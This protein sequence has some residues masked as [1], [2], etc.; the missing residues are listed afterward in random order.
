MGD[1]GG[2]GPEITAKAWSALRESGPAFFVI[3]DPDVFAPFSINTITIQDGTSAGDVF[4]DGL[5]VL[6][7]EKNVDG[8]PGIAN[9]ANAPAILESIQRAV[10]YGLQ[11]GGAI[12]T[13]PIQKSSLMKAGFNFPGH[14]EYLAA[15]T[16]DAPMPNGRTR[17]PVMM[18]AGPELR[19][20]PVTIHKAVTDAIASLTPALII[21]CARVTA[22]ALVDDF[23]IAAPRLTISGLNPHAGEEGAMGHE[24]LM[25]IQPA[26]DDL[27]ARGLNVTGPV[28]ADGMFHKGARTGYDAALCML[29][30]QALIPVKT[31]AFDDSVNVTLGLPIV[32]TSPDHGTALNIAGE[33]IARADSLIASLHLGAAIT[34]HRLTK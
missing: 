15:L 1:P 17:G 24:D 30:D 34:A 18:L 16:Q 10:A 4:S 28:A 3:A 33:N 31:L 9:H 8:A 25:I 32:R 14:T 11:T 26:I 13:N 12:V 20:V 5:P 27:R 29:H 22:E 21:H 6:P 23:G 19:T 7:L 2:I